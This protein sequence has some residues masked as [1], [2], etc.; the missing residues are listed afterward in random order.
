M[1]RRSN[2]V[3]S[4]NFVATLLLIALGAVPLLFF[5]GWYFGVL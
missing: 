3:K 4:D 2:F 5:L 1:E